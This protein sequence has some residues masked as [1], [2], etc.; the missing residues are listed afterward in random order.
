MAGR[1]KRR[2]S[3]K[4]VPFAT[5][6]PTELIDRLRDLA[7]DRGVTIS[8]IVDR[9]LNAAMDKMLADGVPGALEAER[10]LGVRQQASLD[11]GEDADQV[12]KRLSNK[13]N[14]PESA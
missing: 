6:L 5:Y 9:A 1:I 10:A 8:E 12:D 11:S 2:N 3:P 4:K 13:G 14:M 7:I